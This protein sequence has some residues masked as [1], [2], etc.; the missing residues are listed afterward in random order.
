MIKNQIII[1]KN[2][3][4]AKY[5]NLDTKIKSVIEKLYEVDTYN[6]K[7]DLTDNVNIKL[8][9][10]TD[11]FLKN[12]RNNDKLKEY[13]NKTGVYIFMKDGIPLYIGFS[14]SRSQ[15]LKKRIENQFSAK[16]NSNSNLVYKI[17]K[18]EENLDYVSLKNNIND[19]DEINKILQ[20][21]KEYFKKPKKKR[22]G[23]VKEI[24]FKRLQNII[25]KYTS[26]LIVIDCG[27][28]Q[29]DNISFAQTLEVILISLFNSKYNG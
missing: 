25:L 3:I 27:E 2:E 23:K 14:G 26:S 16:D 21:R 24:D 29:D 17:I 15:D 4:L 9:K 13:E 20:L 11:E 6:E 19:I 5:S 10:I 28:K 7:N 18:V 8:L 22:R 12:S 1:S